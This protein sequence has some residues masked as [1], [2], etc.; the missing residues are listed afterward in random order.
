MA[1]ESVVKFTDDNF[2]DEALKSDTPV[3]VDFWGDSCQPCHMLAPLIDKFADQYK[4]KVKVGKVDT[5]D[6][7]Q[8]AMKYGITAIPTVILL[9]GG[10]E[11]GRIRG[12]QPERVYTEELDK[13][14]A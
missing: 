13:L 10:E 9:K 8:V 5:G 4:D 6:N 14:L 2:E 12:L 7:I 1:S 11:V 3:L